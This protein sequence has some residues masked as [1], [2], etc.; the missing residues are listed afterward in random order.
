MSAIPPQTDGTVLR[1]ATSGFQ[2]QSAPALVRSDSA[3]VERGGVIRTL[4]GAWAQPSAPPQDTFPGDVNGD[5]N[6]TTDAL[7]GP[8]W[9]LLLS[10]DLL[11]SGCGFNVD[12]GKFFAACTCLVALMQGG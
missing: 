1:R 9:S 6:S 12:N 3:D 2:F 11:L 10:L 4:E 5:A 7:A 8:W